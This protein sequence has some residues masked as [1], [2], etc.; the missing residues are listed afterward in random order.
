MRGRSGLAVGLLAGMALDALFADP[1]KRHPVAAFGTVAS[2]VERGLW[3]DSRVRGLCFALACTGPLAVVSELAVRRLPGRPTAVLTAVATWAVLGGASLA[4]EAS[5]LASCLEAG[6]LASARRRLPSLCGRDPEGLDGPEIAR[7]A[8]E[9]VAE[10][11]C[12][13]VVAPLFW[14]A[15]YG[16][17]GL[18]TYRAVN[19]LDAMVGHRNPRYE[20]FGWAAARL[21]DLANLLPARM[22]ALLAAALAPAVGGNGRQAVRMLLRDGY[23]HPSPNG[24][25][26][27]SAFAGA[28]GVRLGGTNTYQGRREER[29]KLGDGPPPSPAD[30]RRAVVLSRLAGASAAAIAALAAWRAARIGG[31]G[32]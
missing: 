6:D 23:S 15:I 21:D 25:Q 3:A 7:A 31:G 9:S 4:A 11:T 22:T 16:V 17:P 24:G 32:L 5:A 8:V 27:E 2:G 20:R 29:G 28:L 14:G 1:A 30:I 12:D 18:L 10:N 19:T 13:A 26:C